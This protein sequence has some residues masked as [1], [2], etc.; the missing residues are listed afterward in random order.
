MFPG[1]RSS[2]RPLWVPLL[3]ED[4]RVL[5]ENFIH[6]WGP[7]YVA[8]KEFL[9]FDKSAIVSFEILIPGEYSV[10]STRE[11]TLDGKKLPP[12]ST[13]ELSAGGHSILTLDG[14]RLRWGRELFLPLQAAPTIPIFHG[15]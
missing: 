2:D 15:Y 1:S 11:V 8:G 5:R 7:I 14:A 9:T 4:Q 13:V 3:D 6:H 12:H 10:E